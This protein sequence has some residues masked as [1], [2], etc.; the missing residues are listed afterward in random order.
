MAMIEGLKQYT[1]RERFLLLVKNDEARSIVADWAE[2]NIQ[3]DLRLRR[4]KTRGHT[5]IETTDVVFANSIMQW[6]P[7]AQVVIK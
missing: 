1:G 3:S 6:Y 5:V 4:A 2:R 7:G